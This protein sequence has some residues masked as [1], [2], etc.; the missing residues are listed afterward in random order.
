MLG[1]SIFSFFSSG[2]VFLLFSRFFLTIP[3]THQNIIDWMTPLKTLVFAGVFIIPFYFIG[4]IFT[5]LFARNRNQIGRLYGVD[6]IGAAFGC[7]SVPIAFHFLDLPYIISFCLLIISLMTAYLRGKNIL[8]SFLVLLTINIAMLQ[9]II[10]LE[11][12][13]DIG[14]AVY[15]LVH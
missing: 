8:L 15:R 9:G 13:Y 11:S 3:I 14:N 6:L 7:L 5:R 10:F 1:L 12:N 4:K 2:F